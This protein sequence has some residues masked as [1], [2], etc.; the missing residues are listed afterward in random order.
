MRT[1]FFRNGTIILASLLAGVAA[2]PGTTISQE[3]KAGHSHSK[4]AMHGGSVS[5]SKNYH[6]EVVFKPGNV[7]VYLYDG[8]QNPL[9]AKGVKGEVTLKFK[10][11]DPQKLPLTYV[12]MHHEMKGSHHD[13]EEEDTHKSEHGE[14][15]EHEHHE[16][17]SEQHHKMKTMAMDYLQAS[18]D[19]S[20][21]KAGAMKAVFALKGLPSKTEPE[22]TFTETF[23]GFT[24]NKERQHHE[25][26]KH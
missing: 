4:A 16:H 19:L 25:T 15:D 2:L 7:M 20:D 6:F 26:H 10:N 13:M 1:S 11:G 23:G 9:S 5:M 21:V 17:E 22:V 8:A 3:S 18:V 24:G 14:E 12:S